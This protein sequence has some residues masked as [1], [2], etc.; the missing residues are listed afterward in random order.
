MSEGDARSLLHE[1]RL[2]ERAV[3]ADLHVVSAAVLTL[4]LLALGG[5]AA[6]LTDG[7]F[8]PWSFVYWGF[9]APAGLVLVVALSTLAQRRAGIRRGRGWLVAALAVM[10]VAALVGV[11]TPG[12]GPALV[13]LAFCAVAAHERSPLLG[14]SAVALAVVV[15][16]QEL[17]GWF[18]YSLVSNR[19]PGTAAGDLMAAHGT[20]VVEGLLGVVLVVVALLAYRSERA[21]R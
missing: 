14:I 15:G 11:F 2:V 7:R 13:G 9:A 18:A 4:G 21:V 5:A 17:T 16:I 3:R 8:S 1:L 12:G 20:A 19:F 10:V 6:A